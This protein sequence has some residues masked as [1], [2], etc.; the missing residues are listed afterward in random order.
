MLRGVEQKYADKI[1][2]CFIG[3][4]EL[5]MMDTAKLNLILRHFIEIQRELRRELKFIIRCREKADLKRLS[6]MERCLLELELHGLH[7]CLHVTT[8]RLMEGIPGYNTSPVFDPLLMLDDDYCKNRIRAIEVELHYINLNV[9]KMV[10][11][12]R[13]RNKRCTTPHQQCNDGTPIVQSQF[14]VNRKYMER[15]LEHIQYQINNRLKMAGLSLSQMEYI[16]FTTLRIFKRSTYIMEMD[17]FSKNSPEIKCEI[18]NRAR[19]D[20]IDIRCIGTNDDVLLARIKYAYKTF[21][22]LTVWD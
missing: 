2:S 17:R 8:D 6:N 13:D 20:G 1:L 18:L 4:T 12:R 7:K 10:V 21:R 11:E 15:H 22:W 14:T 5:Q 19:I 9:K 3:D 16:Y